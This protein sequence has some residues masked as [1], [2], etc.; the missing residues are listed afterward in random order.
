MAPVPTSHKPLP[1]LLSQLLG[2]CPGSTL[3]MSHQGVA[4]QDLALALPGQP[5]GA[6]AHLQQQMVLEDPLN[7]FQQEA[8]QRQ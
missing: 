8:L 7:R 6:T 3:Q 5:P 4:G 2:T 1:Q